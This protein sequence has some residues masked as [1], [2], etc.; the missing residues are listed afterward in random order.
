MRVAWET[1]DVTVLPVLM[2]GR[3]LSQTVPDFASF[4]LASRSRVCCICYKTYI[5][6]YST[7]RPRHRSTAA[8]IVQNGGIGTG[9]FADSEGWELC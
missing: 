8:R 5:H 1:F 2:N 9:S 7:Q 6:T 3:A 4:D